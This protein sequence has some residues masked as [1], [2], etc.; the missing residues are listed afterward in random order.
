MNKIFR[1]VIVFLLLLSQPV[2]SESGLPDEKAIVAE[3]DKLVDNSAAVPEKRQKQAIKYIRKGI[4]YHDKGDFK[5]AIKQYKKAIDKDPLNS[6]AYYELSMSQYSARELE[7]AY[8]SSIR[9]IALNPTNEGAYIM[10][11]SILDDSGYPDLAINEYDRLI[12]INPESYMA[13]LN[14]GITQIKLEHWIEAEE[15]MLKANTIDNRQASPYFY[16]M[17]VCAKQGFNYDEERY[18]KEFMRVGQ[19]DGRRQIV[20]QR[21]KE[22][23]STTISIP[24]GQENN[25]LL[26]LTELERSLWRTEKHRKAYPSE[27]GYR[28]S[29][30][31]ERAVADLIVS[32]ADEGKLELSDKNEQT[33]NRIRELKKKGFLDAANYV[34]LQKHLGSKDLKWKEAHKKLIDDY[35]K[36]KERNS[37]D[38]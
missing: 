20:E 26:M 37:S 10:K 19:Q 38:S 9:A 36:W 34:R 16:L 2:S 25:M 14:K 35:L 13:W 28:P 12:G 32:V 5:R 6:T 31:E 30:E 21:L 29:L 7:A 23:D 22:L 18:A 3:M 24:A 15:S 1:Y 27:R 4:K 33:V 8:E 17:Y 11:A